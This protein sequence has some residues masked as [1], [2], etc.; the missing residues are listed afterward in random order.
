[1]SALAR[2]FLASGK[3]VYGYDR[4]QTTLTSQLA[5]EGANIHYTENIELI[6]D[7]T[8]L[9]IYTPA[10]NK[11]GIEFQHIRKKGFNLYKRSEILGLLTKGNFT[12]AVAGTHG[13]TTITSI[14]AEILMENNKKI[15]AFFGGISKNYNTNLIFDDNPDFFIVEADEY[16]RS[17]LSIEPDIAIVSAVDADHLDIYHNTDGLKES[18]KNFVSK[19]KP[20]GKLIS[21]IKV[22]LFNGSHPIK[23]EYAVDND[24]A[25]FFASNLRVDG[26]SNLFDL[27]LKEL[28]IKDIRLN[29]PGRFN[30][31]NCVAAAAVCYLLDVN[32]ESI[33]KA[34]GDYKGVERRFDIRINSADFVYLDD[35]A[36]HPEEIKAVINS[37]REIFPGKKLTCI[38]QPHL[39]TRTRDL[40]DEFAESLS[41]PDEVI[42]LDIYPARENPIEGIS[43]ELLLH[44]IEKKEKRLF[45]KQELIRK[46]EDLETDILITLGAGDIDRLV[47]PIEHILRKKY[48]KI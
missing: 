47:E 13:K 33:K 44:K 19:T 10:I 25:D 5:S 32:T 15:A 16:D 6:P 23:L 41:L 46:I 29:I 1:M 8:D 31:E 18:F 28:N 38:F 11:T 34:I 14:I 43:S 7:D 45:S 35:Y 22:K 3:S 2:F 26:F 30:V 36:H 17:F 42:L 40:S 12:I 39:Y 9:V 20:G 24:S 21:N 48:L 27:T 37:I 4:I